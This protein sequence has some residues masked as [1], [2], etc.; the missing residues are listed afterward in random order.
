[1]LKRLER[2]LD[3]GARSVSGQ[4][5]GEILASTAVTDERTIATLDKPFSKRPAIVIVRGSLLPGGG[6][7]RLGGTGERML[8]FRGKANIF[9]SRDEALAAIKANRVQPGDVVVLRGL[10]VVGGPGM[11]MTSAVIFALDGAG[12]L[13]RVAAITEGQLSGL[14]NNGL[15]VGEASPEAAA[16]GPLGLLENG[17]VISIDVRRK[18]VDLEVPESVLSERRKTARSFG[19]QDQRGW[20]GVYQRTVAP[21]H[22]GAVLK[23]T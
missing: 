13:D 10:G 11:A 16:G 17:D 4:T 22:E 12:L 7:V 18:V 20:L 21:V 2:Q 19:A 15:V 1:V 6:I 23:S 8:E 5:L 14:V 3:L 9:H